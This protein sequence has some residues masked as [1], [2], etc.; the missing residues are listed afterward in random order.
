MN[1]ADRLNAEAEAITKYK[2]LLQPYYNI[3]GMRSDACLPRGTARR[4]A[5]RAAGVISE[6]QEK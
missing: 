5:M 2:P 4:N 6:E 3:V 1:A